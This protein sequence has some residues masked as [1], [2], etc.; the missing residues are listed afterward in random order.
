MD[1]IEYDQ[2][3]EVHTI[4]HECRWMLF[5]VVIHQQTKHMFED[6]KKLIMEVFGDFEPI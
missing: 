5:T 2:F 4:I 1:W 6:I 3:T